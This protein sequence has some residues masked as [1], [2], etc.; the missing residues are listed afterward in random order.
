M[1]IQPVDKNTVKTHSNQ[2]EGIFWF[3]VHIYETF[4]C[5]FKIFKTFVKSIL[6]QSVTFDYLRVGGCYITN[7]M[8]IK[9]LITLLTFVKV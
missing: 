4:Y 7:L 1:N 5:S 9:F 3:L 8:S 2:C 6:K